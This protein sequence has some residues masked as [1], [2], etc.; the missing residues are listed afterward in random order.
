MGMTWQQL[1]PLNLKVDLF[2][3]V[4]IIPDFTLIFSVVER[5]EQ[6]SV[7]INMNTTHL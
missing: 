2:V 6:S 3:L 4:R 7:T 1:L 5:D